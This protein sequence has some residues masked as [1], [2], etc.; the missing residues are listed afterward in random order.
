MHYKIAD[1]S[2]IDSGYVRKHIAW[3]SEPCGRTMAMTAFYG[4]K[5]CLLHFVIPR[6]L[7]AYALGYGWFS[8]SLPQPSQ[9][10]SMAAIFTE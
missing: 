6:V 1:Q 3:S 5:R 4:S 10:A 2:R 8:G 9:P 7:Y